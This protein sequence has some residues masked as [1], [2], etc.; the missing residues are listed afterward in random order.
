MILLDTTFLVDVLRGKQSIGVKLEELERDQLATTEINV[1]EIF[2]GIYSSKKA[3]V[4]H[5]SKAALHL[6]SMLAVLPLNRKAT[7]RSAEFTGSLAKE[8]KTIGELD[9]LIA[10]IALE[11]GITTILTKNKDHFERIP[12]VQVLSY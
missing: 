8:G 3:N 9:C 4:N 12:G 1:F 6:F 5:E 11:H 10:G 7:I 2:T